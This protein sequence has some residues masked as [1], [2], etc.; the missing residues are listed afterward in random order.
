MA[1]RKVEMTTDP[2]VTFTI[3][4]ITMVLLLMVYLFGSDPVA[5]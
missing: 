2:R 3:V 4:L 1:K 5:L